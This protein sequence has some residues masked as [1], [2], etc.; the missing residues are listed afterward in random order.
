MPR[1][2][3]CQHISD[4]PPL[5]GS[6]VDKPK[7][8]GRPPDQPWWKSGLP[9]SF[10]GCPNYFDLSSKEFVFLVINTKFRYFLFNHVPTYQ[11][12]GRP[13]GDYDGHVG[14]PHRV[15][16]HIWRLG[17]RLSSALLWCQLSHCC[18]T[19]ITNV[20]SQIVIACNQQLNGPV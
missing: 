19:P 1:Y 10:L 11:E 2:Q 7:F 9:E 3:D 8:M 14:S 4:V 5:C 20:A 13:S 15:L 18:V 16:G 17:D 12:L 6:A